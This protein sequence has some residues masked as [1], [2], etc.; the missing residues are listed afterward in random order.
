AEALF[1]ADEATHAAVLV[2]DATAL[3]RNLYLA[4]QV[5][6]TS[7][8][9]VVALTM[10][11]DA[12]KQGLTVDVDAL[13]R[14]L[15]IEVVPVCVPKRTGLGE[16]RAAVTRAL[17]AGPRAPLRVKSDADAAI[18]RVESVVREAGVVVHA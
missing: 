14:A 16:L 7:M 10:M 12:E 15:G 6:E 1:E 8:P 9:A 13:S 18:D 17:E 5:L 3:A 4:L 2:V 11:D